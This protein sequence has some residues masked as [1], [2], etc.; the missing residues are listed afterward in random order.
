MSKNCPKLSK[1][2]QNNPKL[3]G[4][5]CNYIYHTGSSVHYL[6]C[7]CT[8][9]LNLQAFGRAADNLLPD[10]VFSWITG[11]QSNQKKP[12][13]RLDDEEEL[14]EPRIIAGDVTSTVLFCW[15]VNIKVVDSFV[16]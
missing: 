1:N 6:V 8:K 3:K 14:L 7:N 15:M 5:L 13:A 11:G 9:N 12:T 2:V 4:Y 16:F 10:L